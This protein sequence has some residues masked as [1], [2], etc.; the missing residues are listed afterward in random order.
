MTDSKTTAGYIS[1]WSNK[2]QP[3]VLWTQTKDIFDKEVFD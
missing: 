1:I 2:N 3:I